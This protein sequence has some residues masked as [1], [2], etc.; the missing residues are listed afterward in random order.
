MSFGRGNLARRQGLQGV[1]ACQL[2][3][4]ATVQVLARAHWPMVEFPP[5]PDAECRQAGFATGEFDG[6]RNLTAVEFI[7]GPMGNARSHTPNT[8]NASFWIGPRWWRGERRHC[9]PGGILDLPRHSSGA[10][11][12][13]TGAYG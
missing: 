3:P 2:G 8:S 5:K 10:Y 4:F 9:Q 6:C 1:G 11:T 12:T 7:D 13:T